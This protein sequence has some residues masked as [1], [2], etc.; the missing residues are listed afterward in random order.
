MLAGINAV[1]Y[2]REN[3]PVILGRAD[4]YA[5]VLID[6]IVTKGTNEPYR[7]MTSR[8]EYRLLLRQDNADGRLT[9]IGRDAGLVTDERYGMFM[10][11]MEKISM[12]MERLESETISAR[13]ATEFF[14]T[15][16][17]GMK[18]SEILSRPGITYEDLAKMGAEIP[19]LPEDVR[20]QVEIQFKYAGY[21][22]KQAAQVKRFKSVESKTAAR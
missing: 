14:E 9:Q 18:L 5:G 11:K 4:A 19:D 15:E 8:A 17:K 22:K 2:I 10:R 3:P 7:M 21:I 16:T 13:S 1:Q 6:D 12:E 20:E